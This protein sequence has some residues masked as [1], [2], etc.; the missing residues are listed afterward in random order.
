M[1]LLPIT[2]D[3]LNNTRLKMLDALKRNFTEKDAEFLLSF[4]GGEPNWELFDEPSIANLPAVKWKL[5]NVHRLL[6]D[7]AKHQ[8]QFRNLE[9]VLTDW[10]R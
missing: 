9:A 10:L 8:T 6:Q 4:K 7:T 2:L 3:E 5:H 1:T